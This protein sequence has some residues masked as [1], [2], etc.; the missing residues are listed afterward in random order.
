MKKNIKYTYHHAGIPTTEK[1]PGERYS[2]KY[3][4]YTT[5]GDNAFR[6]Q[7]HRFEPDSPLHALIK[8]IPHVAFKVDDLDEAIKGEKI[9]LEP[10]YPLEKFRVALIEVDG[11]PIELIETSLTEEEIWSTENKQGTNLY[12][13]LS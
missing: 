11:A 5:D 6:I 8:T 1:K 12:P 7:W 13:D 4:M 10:Y 3:K 9:L 2:S